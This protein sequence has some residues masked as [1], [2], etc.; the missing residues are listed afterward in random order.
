[1]QRT[2]TILSALALVI[3]LTGTSAYAATQI[4]GASIK[5]GS[6]G[7][8]TLTPDAINQLR[9]AKGDTGSR[10]PVGRDGA[11]GDPGLP[12][13]PGAPGSA[14]A[15]GQPGSAGTSGQPGPA[16]AASVPPV[17]S[18]AVPGGFDPAKVT[19]VTG[20]SV[21]AP[22]RDVVGAPERDRQCA[23]QLPRW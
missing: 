16:G 6:I 12:G 5:D 8:A 20:A 3:S 1:M 9:G 13:A 4:S 10:G 17:G 19:Y 11:T 7:A 14:G 15:A 21:N 22:G 2:P 23:G 18:P